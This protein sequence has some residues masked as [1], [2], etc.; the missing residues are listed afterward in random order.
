MGKRL[1]MAGELVQLQA[2]PGRDREGTVIVGLARQRARDA[3]DTPHAGMLAC[4]NPRAQLRPRW[5]EEQAALPACTAS[6]PDHAAA[7]RGRPWRSSRG[8][9]GGHRWRRWGCWPWGISDVVEKIHWPDE[10]T[11]HTCTCVIDAC[12]GSTVCDVSS[13]M[14]DGQAS[15]SADTMAH[16]CG[17]KAFTRA[18]Q[19]SQAEPAVRPN[20]RRVRCRMRVGSMSC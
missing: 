17:Q 11:Q 10:L 19:R 3:A 15:G 12:D 13:I 5:C 6:R 18:W 9:L 4:G 1:L 7:E 2:P 20:C 16:A 8:L 14:H